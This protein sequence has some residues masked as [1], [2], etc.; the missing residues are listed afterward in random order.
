MALDFFVSH[1]MAKGLFGSQDYKRY[2]LKNIT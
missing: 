2:E 1:L